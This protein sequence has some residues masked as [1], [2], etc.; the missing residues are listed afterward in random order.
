M[1]VLVSIQ[2]MQLFEVAFYTI[3]WDHA[4]LL[5][6]T[7]LRPQEQPRGWQEVSAVKYYTSQAPVRLPRHAVMRGAKDCHTVQTPARTEGD[8]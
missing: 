4:P 3:K 5:P 6:A 2:V 1:R 7:P 8:R